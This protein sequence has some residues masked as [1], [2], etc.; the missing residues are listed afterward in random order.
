MALSLAGFRTPLNGCARGV[1]RFLVGA[2]PRDTPWGP[3]PCS[4]VPRAGAVC[5]P[6]GAHKGPSRR[7][8]AYFGRASLLICCPSCE[9]NV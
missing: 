2:Q 9:L 3:R 1:G 5:G 7:T 8:G 6:S 4:L